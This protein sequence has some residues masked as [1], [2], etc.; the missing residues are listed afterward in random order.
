[1]KIAKTASEPFDYNGA[2]QKRERV[3]QI[4][5]YDAPAAPTVRNIGTRA[6]KPLS[7]YS[8]GDEQ[9]R[10]VHSVRG[11]LI[12]L[13]FGGPESPHNLV[14]MYP[15]FN[16][17]S[18]A[19]G[20][21]ETALAS[22]VKVRG[23]RVNIDIK[24]AY[25]QITSPIPTRILVEVQGARGEALPDALRYP[26]LLN[27]APPI[28]IRQPLDAND[29][30]LR[31]LL[32]NMNREMVEKRWCFEDLGLTAGVKTRKGDGAKPLKVGTHEA[33]IVRKLL[34][35]NDAESFRRY[36]PYAMLDFMREEYPEVYHHVGFPSFQRYGNAEHFG[37]LVP[38]IRKVNELMNDGCLR[39]DLYGITDHER[40]EFL[41][42]A[43][44]ESEAQVDHIAERS[45]TGSNAFSNARVIS[46]R[47]NRQLTTKTLRPI[48]EQEVD[49]A[50]TGMFG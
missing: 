41:M 21:F 50:F 36:R 16:G 26:T 38:A 45:K 33:K 20:K 47:L 7:Q 28:I 1:M 46:G 10:E 43:S 13:R 42:M 8:N 19:W 32:L 25:D 44:T 24:C 48:V 12:G 30:A 2:G 34:K 27:Q 17:P 18:G 39:S 4:T 6:P 40:V 5:V 31:D 9:Y 11:H 37:S 22:W 49:E 3:T 15:D 14:P 29:R 35:Y 23:N